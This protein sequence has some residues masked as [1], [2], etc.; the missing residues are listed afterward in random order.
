MSLSIFKTSSGAVAFA[1]SFTNNIMDKDG[2]ILSLD[3]HVDFVERFDAGE[4]SEIALYFWHIPV[5]IGKAL[6]FA[7]DE[8][9]GFVFVAGI[10]YPEF[11]ALAFGLSDCGVDLGMSHAVRMEDV[12]FSEQGVIERYTP[13]EV[14][15]LPAS[16][17]ANP[18]TVFSIEK[19]VN[20]KKLSQS[21]L[22]EMEAIVGK[23]NLDTLLDK[24]DER[25]SVADAIDI[26]RKEEGGVSIADRAGEPVEEAEVGD[27]EVAVDEAPAD[28]APEVVEVSEEAEPELVDGEVDI[29]PE[30]LAAQGGEVDAKLIGSVVGEVVKEHLA[31]IIPLI[32]ELSKRVDGM[33]KSLADEHAARENQKSI[34]D[35]ESYSKGL[36]ASMASVIGADMFNS[37]ASENDATIIKEDDQLLQGKP[38]E[39][40]GDSN[41]S[42]ESV[43]SSIIGRS[44]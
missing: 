41:G 30:A 29:I 3:S 12:M 10:F 19:G 44:S 37:V 15:V 17:A 42:I 14:S 2:D 11:H 36:R 33:E 43:I 24:I 9:T 1:G 35:K 7:V 18:F 22:D 5:S 23:E 27:G 20:M 28:E 21:K 38:E 26:P 13:F 40:A 34:I 31:Q 39:S 16:R 25:S 32:G 8:E 6:V 4:V